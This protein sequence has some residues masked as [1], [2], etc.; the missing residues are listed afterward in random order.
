MQWLDFNQ[1]AK[2]I[3]ILPFIRV[4]R[5][6]TKSCAKLSSS[7]QLFNRLNVT[8][9]FK[10]KER[11]G[12]K[13]D[14]QSWALKTVGVVLHF[15][16]RGFCFWILYGPIRLFTMFSVL[17]IPNFSQERE[18]SQ[19]VGK[20]QGKYYWYRVITIWFNFSLKYLV[21]TCKFI[22]TICRLTNT[23]IYSQPAKRTILLPTWVSERH[24]DLARILRY[25]HPFP[26]SSQNARAVI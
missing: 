11:E 24:L 18:F 13:T 15:I 20:C 4:N 26:P 19:Q 7:S 21:N 9:F 14:F 16:L 22:S 10:K 17:R 5:K 1:E 12:K 6:D 8:I 3:H 25:S 2:P 23:S